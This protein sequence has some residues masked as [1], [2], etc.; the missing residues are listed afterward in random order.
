[1]EDWASPVTLVPEAEYGK[2]AFDIF[3][4]E[5]WDYA[6]PPGDDG[7]QWAVLVQRYN[8]LTPIERIPYYT[9]SLRLLGS[10]IAGLP[11]PVLNPEHVARVLIPRQT[12]Q[13]RNI[14]SSRHTMLTEPIWLRTCYDAELDAAYWELRDMCEL[15]G[16]TS[17]DPDRILE[18]ATLYD[19]GS[20]KDAILAGVLERIP[21][22][23]DF[24]MTDSP[25][26]LEG[27]YDRLD[28]TEDALERADKEAVFL[29]YVVDAEAIREKLVKI[30]WL[31]IH[32]RCRW[33]SKSDHYD[34]MELRGMF[35]GAYRLVEA[36][37][38]HC[39]PGGGP[40][41]W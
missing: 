3:A 23:C 9:P 36:L 35:L 27:E 25:E 11:V 7:Q 5:H 19:F 14:G 16:Y 31:D 22:L 40:D 20:D 30:M 39:R 24:E 38:S 28:G 2:I 15:G 17:L 32:G 37:E 21:T 18:D 10:T 12:I 41:G 8:A 33:Y 1:M 4:L 26:H 29:M 13:E 6:A 34:V